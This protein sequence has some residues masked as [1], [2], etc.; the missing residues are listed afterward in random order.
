MVFGAHLSQV[1]LW[2]LLSRGSWVEYLSGSVARGAVLA[3]FI[4]SG[5][6]ITRS[7]VANVRRNGYFDPI[8]YLASRI[9]RIYPPFLLA[10]ALTVGI[11]AV[12]ETL[13]LPGASSPLGLLRPSGLTYEYSELWKSAL[14]YNGMISANGPLWSLYIE[15]NLYLVA[16]GVALI[17]CGRS[18]NSRVLGILVFAAAIH[19]GRDHLGYWFFGLIWVFGAALNIPQIKR[20]AV[21]AAVGIVATTATLLVQPFEPESY[22]DGSRF[23]LVIQVLCCLVF[24]AGYLLPSWSERKWPR[25]LTRSADYSYT[26]YVTHFPIFA[27]GLSLAIAAGLNRSWSGALLMLIVSGMT[28]LA[29]AML[30]APSAENTPRFKGLLT[31]KS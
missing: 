25:F 29:T 23:A 17:A 24:A 26:L 12:V 7:I 5:L 18:F 1:F 20:P 27:F 30:L 2:P 31:Q 6:L 11:V 15:V 16:M 10:L 13:N 22:L 21:F 3:F 4:L 28:A 14:L 9:A 19:L 8:D